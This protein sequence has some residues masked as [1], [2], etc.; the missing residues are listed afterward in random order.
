MSVYDATKSWLRKQYPLPWK[1]RVQLVP[2]SVMPESM[3]EFRWLGDRGLIRIQKELSESS[4]AETLIEEHAH[5]LRH[6]VPVAVEYYVEPHDA[7]FWAI[8]GVLV[9]SWRSQ[10]LK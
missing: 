6:A 9:N 5:A 8:Y 10:C 1:C 4:K 7:I 2:E 3:G